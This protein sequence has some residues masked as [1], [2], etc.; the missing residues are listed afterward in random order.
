MRQNFYK[1]LLDEVVATGASDGVLVELYDKMTF[2]M[3]AA[4]VTTGGTVTIEVSL[5]DTN[6][7]VYDTFSVTANGSDTFAIS[8]E[9]HKYVRANV[10]A[11]TDG[12]Y[13]V[14]MMA[15]E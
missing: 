6:Y 14:K 7:T 13:T 5:D 9:K 15:G 11:R 4:D 10:T 8:G 3:T 2:Q 1:T 12:T